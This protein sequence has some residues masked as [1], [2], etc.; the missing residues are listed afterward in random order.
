MHI[1]L[2]NTAAKAWQNAPVL[3]ADGKPQLH[4]D[5][6][7]A[8]LTE[9]RAAR[10]DGS[11]VTIVTVPTGDGGYS[12]LQILSAVA[13]PDGLWVRHS[14]EPPAWVAVPESIPTQDLLAEELGCPSGVPEG[15]DGPSPTEA[16]ASESAGVVPGDPPV[17]ELLP[18]DYPTDAA[19][20][21]GFKPEVQAASSPEV[22]A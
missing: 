7:G 4:P 1:F 15:W 12:R 2:G 22:T 10:L 21:A 13:G 17:S 11:R 6:S 19:L 20:D 3:D 9:E 8:V 5:G 16:L 18:T 14:H